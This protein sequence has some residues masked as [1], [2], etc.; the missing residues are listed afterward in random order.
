[1]CIRYSC[2]PQPKKKLKNNKTEFSWSCSSHV[3]WIIEYNCVHRYQSSPTQISGVH[4]TF[5]LIQ[6]LLLGHPRSDGFLSCKTRAPSLCSCVAPG[7]SAG[8]W[9]VPYL[10]GAQAVGGGWS[11]HCP[12]PAPSTVLCTLCSEP[13]YKGRRLLLLQTQVIMIKGFVINNIQNTHV[14]TNIKWYSVLKVL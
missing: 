6:W 7:W 11:H 4:Q 3:R 5:S 2:L 14:K 10:P 8:I 1:M 13:F 12:S 9:C